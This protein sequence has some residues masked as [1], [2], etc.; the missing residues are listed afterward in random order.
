MKAIPAVT[1]HA[2]Q[3]F[4]ERVDP[5]LTAPTAA[6]AIQSL[7]ASAKAR[8]TPRWW[9][10][11]AGQKPGASYLYSAAHPGVCLVV[12]EDAVVTVFS[13]SACARWRAARRERRYELQQAARSRRSAH[14]PKVA[15]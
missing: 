10:R 2:V 13:R 6:A 4:T 3:R 9:T 14:A 7:A 12:V 15:A 1:R 5:S 11:V 8:P